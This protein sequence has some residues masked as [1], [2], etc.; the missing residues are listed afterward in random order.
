MDYYGPMPRFNRFLPAFLLLCT[1]SANAQTPEVKADDAGTSALSGELFYEILLGE[2]NVLDG[3][4][5]AAHA[6]L[7]D[8]ARKAND[9][10]LYQRAV[11]VALQAHAGDAALSAARAWRQALPASREANRYLLQILI[12]LN[13]LGE[14]S[15][16]IRREVAAADPKDRA[17][18]IANIA[19]YFA[20]G[21]DKKLAALT[22]ERALSEYLAS[23]VLGASAWSAVAGLRLEAGDSAAALE[24]AGKAQAIDPN[25]QEPALLALSLMSREA[26]QAEAI[27]KK[28]LEAQPLPET[29]MAYARA[30][31]DAQRDAQAAEQVQII[32]NEKPDYPPAWLIKGAL[33][34]QNGEADAAEKSF[35]RYV[36]LT[37]ASKAGEPHAQSYRGLMQ[38]YFSLA[39]IAEQRKD[40]AQAQEWLARIDSPQDLLNAQLRVANLL[41]RQ[42]KLDE[43]IKLIRSQDERTPQDARLK[44]LAEAQLLRDSKQYAPAL[45]LLSQASAGDPDDLDLLYDMAMVAEKLNRLDEMERLLRRVIASKPEA[46]HAYNALGFSLAER[47]IR[48]P[49]ARQLIVKAVELAPNDPFIT[50][51]L[52]WLE[53]RSG[54]L[55]QAQLILEGAFKAKADVEIS[56][57]LGEVLWSL[58]QRDKALS[59]WKQGASID[60]E[61][62]TLLETLKRL[63]VKL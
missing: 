41:A 7:L 60:A 4:A 25:A 58:G 43:A 45:A 50:D 35:K 57:H 36:E 22:L 24:A 1:L 54:N 30:L 18:A 51:S 26:P 16:P 47:N 2:L 49:E 15:D 42:G 23:P 10:K 27:V 20:R 46:P 11:D 12:G 34:L 9:N 62:E 59:I 39:R 37:P 28:H 6:L 44:L 19:R 31:L 32:T 63:R 13:R 14:T 52:G 61:N 33:E 38:A 55:A 56:A 5:G 29:R 48:L 53:F 21:S 17:G 3:E 40:F 8:A